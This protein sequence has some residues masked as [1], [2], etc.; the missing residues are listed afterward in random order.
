MKGVISRS[1]TEKSQRDTEKRVYSYCEKTGLKEWGN[2]GEKVRRIE[3]MKE[4]I[5][6]YS[7]FIINSN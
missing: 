4:K 6:N 2:K 7:L 3:G 1:D 5:I